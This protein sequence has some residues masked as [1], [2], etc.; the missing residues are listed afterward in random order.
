MPNV[1][2]SPN[3]PDDDFSTVEAMTWLCL[4][5]FPQV[6]HL[7]PIPMGFAPK[8]ALV[9]LVPQCLHRTQILCIPY[10]RHSNSLER[11][12]NLA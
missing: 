3:I 6:G 12:I 7:V 8:K 10:T 2:R 4:Q 5:L 9:S 1:L 11:V